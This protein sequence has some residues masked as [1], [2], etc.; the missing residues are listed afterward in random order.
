MSIRKH[1]NT[2][3]I[4][5][6]FSCFIFLFIL[7]RTA[8]LINT[9]STWTFDLLAKRNTDAHLWPWG[10]LHCRWGH[11]LGGLCD[12]A[13]GSVIGR[14][15]GH[16]GFYP[17]VEKKDMTRMRGAGLWY[18]FSLLTNWRH[19]GNGAWPCAELSHI[20]DMTVSWHRHTT[21]HSQWLRSGY[22]NRGSFVF[23]TLQWHL[24]GHTPRGTNVVHARITKQNNKEPK[25]PLDPYTQIKHK[26]LLTFTKRSS[27]CFLLICGFKVSNTIGIIIRK[28]HS[29]M[30][31]SPITSET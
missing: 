18:S 31:L 1:E 2:L 11:S 12:H 8:K 10:D 19:G 17:T 13:W 7:G 27:G 14:R 16:T 21:C 29:A 4:N 30:L 20:K 3:R 15:L 22:V 24:V 9:C 6:L 25:T 28:S 5:Y 26:L 23:Q